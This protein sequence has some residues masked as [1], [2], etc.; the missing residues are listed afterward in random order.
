MPCGDHKRLRIYRVSTRRFEITVDNPAT[1]DAF[2]PH[3][4][5]DELLEPLGLAAKDAGGDVTFL[6]ADPV[7]P[8][9]LRL[10][11]AA[12]LA[13][14]AKSVAVAAVPVAVAAVAVES[15]HRD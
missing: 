3:A 11:G 4:A 12:A 7:V 6:G 9:P 8:S 5:L 13:L 10:G 1:D 2:D 14:V 15:W